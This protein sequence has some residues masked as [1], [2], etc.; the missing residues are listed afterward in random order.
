MLG[1]PSVLHCG[2]CPAR[3]AGDRGC[4]ASSSIT[5][6]QGLLLSPSFWAGVEERAWQRLAA[7]TG[8]SAAVPCFSRGG[9][10]FL[11]PH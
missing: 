9:G 2:A 4:G 6:A 8:R 5:T 7:S 1:E 10:S 3:G 11:S